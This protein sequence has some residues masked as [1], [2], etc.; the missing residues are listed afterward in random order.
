MQTTLIHVYSETKTYRKCRLNGQKRPYEKRDGP[1]S[2]SPIRQF[3]T[4]GLK[5]P[6]KKAGRHKMST[7]WTTYSKSLM[8]YKNISIQLLA[9]RA[10]KRQ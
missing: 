7:L 10:N 6:N 2:L 9:Q 5:R 1:I 8:L 3:S 4:L